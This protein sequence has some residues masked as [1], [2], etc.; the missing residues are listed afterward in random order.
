MQKF[1]K[2]FRI[3]FALFRDWLVP[4]CREQHIFKTTKSPIPLEFKVLVA[5]RIFDRNNTADDSNELSSGVIR[6]STCVSI[7]KEF[8]TKMAYNLYYLFV[9]EPEGYDLLKVME[10]YRILGLPGA[11]GSMDVTHVVYGW[12]PMHLKHSCIGKEGI[13]VHTTFRPTKSVML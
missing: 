7:L 3:P 13:T 12:C 2:R 4:I 10:M 5:L 9:C 11:I 1:R 6:E 8:V